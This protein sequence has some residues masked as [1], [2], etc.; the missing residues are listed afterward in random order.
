[1]KAQRTREEQTPQTPGSQVEQIEVEEFTGLTPDSSPEF[2]GGARG[3]VVEPF[4]VGRSAREGEGGAKG[5]AGGFGTKLERSPSPENNAY[6]A[7]AL[8]SFGGRVEDSPVMKPQVVMRGPGR[9][10]VMPSAVGATLGRQRSVP[11]V[12]DESFDGLDDL[13]EECA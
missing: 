13:D 8:E 6:E 7:T 2:T 1:M 11:M 12:V 9:Q 4:H 3:S 10:P 5:A